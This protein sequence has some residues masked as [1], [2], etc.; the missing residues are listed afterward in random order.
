MDREELYIGGAAVVIMMVLLMRKHSSHA[1]T[2]YSSGLSGGQAVALA[3]SSMAMRSNEY[4]TSVAA[5]LADE[6]I[7]AQTAVAKD[8]I[9]ANLQTTAI[10]ARLLNDLE[11]MQNQTNISM[12][13]ISAKNSLAQMKI[14]SQT[15]ENLSTEAWTSK[16]AIASG[17]EP[18]TRGT[19]FSGILSTIGQIFGG[20]GA[21][22]L[23]FL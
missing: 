17:K 6:N 22:I 5:K 20:A 14:K 7:K 12:A 21:A 11:H 2:V 10:K 19:A 1:P 15:L 13:Q 9:A 18:S 23:S 4:R 16:Q 8:K 3:Q